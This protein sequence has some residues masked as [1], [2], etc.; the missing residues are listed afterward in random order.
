[1]SVS[2]LYQRVWKIQS[3]KYHNLCEKTTFFSKMIISSPPKRRNFRS[4]QTVPRIDLCVKTQFVS[5]NS[6]IVPQSTVIN[7]TSILPAVRLTLLVGLTA[8]ETTGWIFVFSASSMHIADFAVVFHTFSV[9]SILYF[10]IQFHLSMF[11]ATFDPVY[12]TNSESFPSKQQQKMKAVPVLMLSGWYNI[13][14]D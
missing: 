7:V 11:Y 10:S 6:H 13:E 4:C 14:G 3:R 12:F 8:T 1:M 9:F 2:M 5:Q